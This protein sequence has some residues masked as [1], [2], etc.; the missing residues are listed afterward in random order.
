MLPSN[1]NRRTEPMS[2]AQSRSV[3]RIAIQ[4]F[5]FPSLILMENAA[6]GAARFL[7][8]RYRP[9]VDG[10]ILVVCGGGNNGG[11]GLAMARHLYNMGLPVSLLLAADRGQLSHDCQVQW[12]IVRKTKMPIA[13]F[14][15][16]ASPIGFAN[17]WSEAWELLSP[18]L[19]RLS[20]IVD[21]VL[22]TGS[23]GPLRPPLD[24]LV[25]KMQAI[26]ATHRMALDLPTGWDCDSGPT[27]PDV[28]RATVTYTFVAHKISFQHP[29]AAEFLGEIVVGDIGVPPEVV[30]RVG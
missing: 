27:G 11:D 24:L 17:Q 9:E 3:D 15:P 10:G 23:T 1:L 6:S 25:R 20:W 12:Q 21:A 18:V 14:S 5:G 16:N 13:A 30:Q 19:G 4:E 28:F 7:Q 8:S 26:P 2:R 29:S 22:G